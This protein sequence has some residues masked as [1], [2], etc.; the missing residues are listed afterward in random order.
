MNFL[1]TMAAIAL[2]SGSSIALAQ[3]NHKNE[4]PK[5]FTPP[6]SLPAAPPVPDEAASEQPESRLSIP[7]STDQAAREIVEREGLNRKQ[8]EFASNQN[9]E[10]EAARAAYEKA[11]RDREETIARQQANYQAELD[12]LA[13]EHAEAMARWEAD[14]AA[15]KKGDL[16]RC[17]T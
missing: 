3:S 13:R 8:A 10:N 2:I 11:L 15:C 4:P 12:R 17:G 16:S 1:R 5:R 7:V 14:V 6:P 9:A